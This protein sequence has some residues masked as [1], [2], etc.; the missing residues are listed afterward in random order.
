MHSG[1]GMFVCYVN[2]MTFFAGCMVLHAKRVKSNRHCITC[3]QT[4]SARVLRADNKSKIVVLLCAGKPPRHIGDEDSV[5][6]RIPR[7]IIAKVLMKSPTKAIVFIIFLAY[8]S[9]TMWGA[10]RVET[11]LKLQ[12]IVSPDS[13]FAR[14]AR[15]DAAYFINHGPFVQFVIY[16]PYD[17]TDERFRLRYEM[18]VRKVNATGYMDKRFIISWY[19][20]YRDYLQKNHTVTSKA[21]YV[22]LLRDNFLK[23][24]P[25]YKNDVVF[26]C[27]DDFSPPSCTIKA[28]RFYF[29]SI[30]FNDS[31]TE[32]EMMTRM[33]EIAENSSLPIIAYSSSFIFYEHYASILTDTLLAVGVAIIGMLFIALMFIPH[34]VSIS[35]VTV[36]MVT[37]VLGMLGFLHFWGIEL[38]AVI[39]VQVSEAISNFLLIIHI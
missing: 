20:A 16:E 35:C 30:H 23:E 9:I 37:I 27:D 32:S 11:G 7:M 5:F 31:K 29:S 15:K 3:A 39:T 19:K 1:V 10:T 28:S 33:R 21:N 2:Q 13:Y 22:M 24:H 8:L 17:Y 36:S 4:R 38:S 26:A 34:P 6:E 14:F 12:N 25:E 18:I